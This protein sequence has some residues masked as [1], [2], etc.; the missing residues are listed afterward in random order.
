MSKE[1]GVRT[2]LV[3]GG[4]AGSL[5][6]L[7]ELVGRLPADLP[8]PVL[9][10]VHVGENGRSRLAAILDRGGRLPAE[11]ARDGE[12]A[13]DGHV[14]VAPP[15]RHLLLGPDG[16][17]L[18]AGPR[19]NRHRPAIDVMFAS[20]AATVGRG[21]V[22]VVLSGVLDDGAVGA[23]LVAR[24]GG[25]VL[26]QAD[27]EFSS[28]PNAALHAAPGAQHVPAPELASAAL[29]RVLA[30]AWDRSPQ[31]VSTMD[32]TSTGTAPPRTDHHGGTPNQTM[33]GSDDVGYL[34]PGES[35]L[36]RLSCPEC[37]GAMAQVDLPR[38]SYFVCHVGHRYSPQ[39]LAAAQAESVESKLWAAVA[40]L[41]EQA[42][43]L[44][45]LQRSG[46]QRAGADTVGTPP[47]DVATRARDL[48]RQVQTW[49]TAPLELRPEA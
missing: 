15:G 41:E 2:A 40:A 13:R 12:P 14:Y 10:T 37:S 24:A 29:D 23:A 30:S 28:M 45:H 35:R 38:I 5:G 33:A 20:V 47:P 7:L 16:L 1:E 34:A 36:T 46:P 48:R 8:A 44:A 27:A 43:V 19:V 42:A 32:D 6:A 18:S 39:T 17:S 3:V 31:E 26:V 22:A 21:T 11:V 25:R 9:V 4:S 49:S